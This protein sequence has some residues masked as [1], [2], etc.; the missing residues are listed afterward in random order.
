MAKTRT[1]LLP[2]EVRDALESMGIEGSSPKALLVHVHN[3]LRRLFENE[4]IEQVLRDGKIAFKALTF[5]D[6]LSLILREHPIVAMF[7]AIP[8]RD[9]K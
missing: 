1:A 6:K 2:T 7:N 5:S 4:E 8:R 9:L 3:V